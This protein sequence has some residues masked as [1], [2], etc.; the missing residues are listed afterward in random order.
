MQAR[1]AML[2]T[3]LRLSFNSST[4]LVSV[5]V[6]MGCRPDSPFQASSS[7]LLACMSFSRYGL[8]VS[9]I[10]PYKGFLDMTENVL[11]VSGLA[12]ISL[13]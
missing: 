3:R 5:L 1:L 8:I 2:L 7:C 9:I 13:R 6:M 4:S 12:V 11:S 10:G